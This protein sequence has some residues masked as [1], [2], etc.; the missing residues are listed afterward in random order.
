MPS[1]SEAK[2]IF[3]TLRSLLNLQ[4]PWLP[5]KRYRS[6]IQEYNYVQDTCALEISGWSCILGGLL[7]RLGGGRGTVV[8][9]ALSSLGRADSSCQ[10][11]RFS[12]HCISITST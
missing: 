9:V 4:G 6:T 10:P 5:T 2:Q 7:S 8:D 1:G 3:L 12:L 11:V